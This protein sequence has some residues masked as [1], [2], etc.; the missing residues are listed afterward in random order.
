MIVTCPACNA[1]YKINESKIK[2]RGAK[3]TCPRC[4]HRFIVYRGQQSAP[5]RPARQ[6]VADLDFSTLGITWRVRKG[7]GVVW[8]FN[9]LGTLQAWIEQGRVEA[10]DRLSYDNR[11]WASVDSISDFERHFLEIWERARRGEIETEPDEEDP[12]STLDEDDE[13]APTT[14]V[15][16]GSNLASEIRQAVT[17]EATP[18][19]PFEREEGTAPVT[20]PSPQPADANAPIE[21]AADLESEPQDDPDTK[22][23]TST[24]SKPLPTDAPSA[25]QPIAMGADEDD[26]LMDDSYFDDSYAEEPD[27]EDPPRP[28]EPHVPIEEARDDSA[29]PAPIEGMTSFD[30]APLDPAYNDVVP[31]PVPVPERNEQ[32]RS[33]D[34]LHAE[35]I[36]SEETL[37]PAGNP[38]KARPPTSGARQVTVERD[39]GTRALALGVGS[40]VLAVVLVLVTLLMSGVF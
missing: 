12:P 28:P 15:G 22:A 39:T 10:W 16:R 37:R 25:G 34:P 38:L 14:I 31:T 2:G 29:G 3:I 21:A 4:A 13:D 24:F 19:R 6:K 17:A 11:T 26:S 30:P 20:P 18:T 5:V 36:S 1:R 8:D 9:T 23:P 33:E 27:S 32:A 40:V 7:L 35:P